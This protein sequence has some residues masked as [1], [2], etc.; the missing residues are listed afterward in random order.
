MLLF[1]RRAALALML[2]ALAA[3]GVELP[4]QELTPRLMY[5]L[6][7]GEV[8]VQ[9]DRLGL[10]VKTYMELV[11]TTHDPRIAQRAAEIALYAHQPREALEAIN[12]WIQSDPHSAEAREL[13]ASIMLGLGQPADVRETLANL[14]ASNKTDVGNDFRTLSVVFAQLADHVAGLALA[15]DLAKP[16]PQLPEARYLVASAA[17][18]AGNNDRALEAAR[19]A[20]QLRPGWEPA[21]LLEVRLLQERDPA[22]ARAYYLDFLKQ[23]PDARDVRLLYARDLVEHKEYALAREQFNAIL[24]SAPDNPDMAFAVALLTIQLKDVASAEPLLQKALD[25]GYHDQDLVRFYLG[26][27]AEEQKQWARAAQWYGAVSAGEQLNEARV[28]AALMTAHVS[29]LQ[30]GLELLQDIEGKTPEQKLM[31]VLANEQM[32]REAGD[33]SGAFTVLTEA[34]RSTPDSADLLYERAIVAE[35]LNKTDLVEQDL[36]QVIALRPDYAHAYNALGYSFADRAVRLDEALALIQ[37][38]LT[39]SPNDPF[40]LDSLGWVEFRMGKMSESIQALKQAYSLQ[41]DPEI[42]AHLGEA[43]WKAGDQ[44][45]ARNAWEESLKINPD[46]EPLRAT[47]HRFV[48]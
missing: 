35:K 33:Y 29:G 7:L 41:E 39:L 10:S 6:L 34:L 23:Y 8:A 16:Y 36:R 32:R 21:A 12:V 38:A 37:K 22:L 3:Q 42:A 30:K 27:A 17:Y 40:I 47:M 19:R 24:T 44:G 45:A 25:N 28:R 11:R 5:Q 14:L 31:V 13:L 43:L 1:F 20:L 15:E 48:P 2:V 9:R 4:T 46:N 18:L 26:Q